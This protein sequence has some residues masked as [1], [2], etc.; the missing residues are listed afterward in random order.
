M[1]TSPTTAA[2][3][4]AIGLFVPRRSALRRRSDRIELAVRWVLLIVGLLLLP[5]ALTAGSEASASTAALAEAQRAQLHQV[6]AEV[7]AGPDTGS[8]VRPDATAGGPQAS[9]RWIAGDGTPRVA[10]VRAPSSTRAGDAR[11]IWV[12]RADRPAPAPLEPGDAATQGALT[13]MLVVLGDLVV[14]WLLLGALRV[15]LDRRRLR[16]WDAAW[17]RFSGPDHEKR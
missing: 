12:D 6:S 16:E 17:R 11:T 7:L 5:I 8:P 9:V 13:V 2:L 15:V 1:S 14:S 10:L 4:R 3:Q